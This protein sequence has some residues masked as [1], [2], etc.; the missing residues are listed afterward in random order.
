M[1]PGEP[2]MG[3][4]RDEEGGLTMDENPSLA[5]PKSQSRGSRCS[6]RMMFEAFMSPCTI[7]RALAPSWRYDKA[8]ATWYAIDILCFHVRVTDLELWRC[9]CRFPFGMYSKTS[10]PSSLS[11]Q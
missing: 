1:Y 3:M 5:S 8:W 4:P 9:S 7:W 10:T 11:S 6:S 2:T